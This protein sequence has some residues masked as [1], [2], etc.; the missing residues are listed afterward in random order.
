MWRPPGAPYGEE[1]LGQQD[2][3]PSHRAFAANEALGGQGVG[4]DAEEN[5]P[6]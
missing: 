2:F 4:P 5:T 3:P 6:L 1:P